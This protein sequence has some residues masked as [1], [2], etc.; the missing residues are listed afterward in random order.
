MEILF[1]KGE[2]AGHYAENAREYGRLVRR[3]AQEQHQSCLI[4]IASEKLA[5]LASLEGQKVRS[6]TLQGSQ[7]IAEQILQEKGL[8]ESK[9]LHKIHRTIWRQSPRDQNDFVDR[10]GTL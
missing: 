1:D 8:K 2:L 9:D 6:L 3:I 7:E 5:E 10:S 4:S